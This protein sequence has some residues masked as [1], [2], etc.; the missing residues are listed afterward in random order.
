MFSL[1][2]RRLRGE[3][4]MIVGFRYFKGSHKEVAEKLFFSMGYRRRE[5]EL[6]VQ[7]SSFRSNLRKVFLPIRT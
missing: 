6:K 4:E 3:G 2:K 1:K 5:K 7:Q